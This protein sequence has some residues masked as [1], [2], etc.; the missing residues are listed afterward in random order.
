MRFTQNQCNALL[1][2]MQKFRSNNADYA[3]AYNDKISPVLWWGSIE[4]PL[5]NELQ[6]NRTKTFKTG[7]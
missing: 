2:Q 4:D 6:K 3:I 1:A 7:S 5:R